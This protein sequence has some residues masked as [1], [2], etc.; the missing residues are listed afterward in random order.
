MRRAREM[1]NKT[2]PQRVYNEFVAVNATCT[3]THTHTHTH[4]RK[5]FPVGSI[6]KLSLFN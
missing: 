4:T 2:N 6:E 3:R 5:L 1:G